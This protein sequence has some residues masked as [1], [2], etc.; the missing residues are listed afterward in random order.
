MQ[1]EDLARSAAQSLEAKDFERARSLLSADVRLA[2]PAV[3][4]VATEV[5]GGIAFMTG[6][7]RDASALFERAHLLY[8]S[9]HLVHGWG[10]LMQIE[11]RLNIYGVRKPW[12]IQEGRLEHDTSHEFADQ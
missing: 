1:A 8:V 5:L 6:R 2:L 9:H 7:Y 11:R 3:E 12:F 4:A 10:F